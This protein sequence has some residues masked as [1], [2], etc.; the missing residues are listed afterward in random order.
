M[1]TEDDGSIQPLPYNSTEDAAFETVPYEPDDES[2][3]QLL[4]ESE[5]TFEYDAGDDSDIVEI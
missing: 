2:D 4:D 3:T 5:E 1:S